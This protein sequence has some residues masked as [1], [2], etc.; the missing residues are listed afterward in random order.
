[1]PSQATVTWYPHLRRVA[2]S[3]WRETMLSSAMRMRIIGVDRDY[4]P[5]NHIGSLALTL[6]IILYSE[7]VPK[8][9][10]EPSVLVL[11]HE[12]FEHLG[13][14]SRILDAHG[15][16]FSYHDLSQPIEYRGE[17]R[18]VIL[19]GPMSANDPLPGL[20]DELKLI[21]LALASGIPM[22]GVC[23]G[24]QLIARALGAPVYRN[25]ELEI[26]WKPVYFTETAK[27]DRVFCGF[28]DQE[29]FFHWHGETF[30]LP[31]G[32][33]HLAWSDA[34]LNQAYRYGERVYGI[35]FHPEIT[36]E[37]I[38]DWVRQPVNCGDVAKLDDPIDAHAVDSAESSARII[39][40]WLAV[41]G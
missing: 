23:L 2:S 3:R 26:G 41:G 34:C 16:P 33:E 37:M 27:K 28:R 5:S 24:S 39:D 11:R 18:I 14:F 7:A 19:G 29:T 36:A 12:P 17:S 35:Q 20:A 30:D 31:R 32:A 21:E 8:K 25:R 1:M 38:E 4:G 22:L 6:E 40:G 13:G 15:L 9:I 10:G